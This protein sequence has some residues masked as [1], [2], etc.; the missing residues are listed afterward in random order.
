MFTVH[1][2]TDETLDNVT[3]PELVK[4]ADEGKIQSYEV[5]QEVELVS[6][7]TQINTSNR[8]SPNLQLVLSKGAHELLYWGGCNT[9]RHS[10]L[11]SDEDIKAGYCYCYSGYFSDGEW[12]VDCKYPYLNLDLSSR[13][14][15]EGFSIETRTP[16]SDE[17]IDNLKAQVEALAKSNK[18]KLEAIAMFSYEQMEALK[19]QF[20]FDLFSIKVELEA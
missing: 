10:V 18:D 15:S 3:F 17:E 1:T 20:G 13:V 8:Y 2:I 7:E 14:D 11:V 9:R 4:L 16:L 19:E 12:T 6:M 5:S